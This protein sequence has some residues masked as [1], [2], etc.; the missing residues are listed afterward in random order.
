MKALPEDVRPYKRTPIFTEAT[1]P[2]G[3]LKQ[4]TTKEGAWAK[5]VV[6][7]GRLLYRILVPDVSEVLL[8]PDQYGVVEPQVPH[9]VSPDG[10]VRFFVE[11]CRVPRE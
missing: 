1:V 10:P 11:F 9:E 7:E 8:T 5:I 3:L 6:L 2:P 4:H